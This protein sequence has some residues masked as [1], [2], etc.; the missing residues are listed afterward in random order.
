MARTANNLRSWLGLAENILMNHHLASQT[1]S[2]W[3]SDVRRIT[4]RLALNALCW[5]LVGG[6][7]RNGLV[8]D[9]S[10]E[11]AK[12]QRPFLGGATPREVQL[13]FEVPGIDEVMWAR[14]D[15]CYDQVVAAP[16]GSVAGG[17]LGLMRRTG[18]RII[19]AAQR[20]L[21]LIRDYVHELRRAQWVVEQEAQQLLQ[22][23]YYMRG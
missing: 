16:V 23:S 18:F 22:A 4:P 20:D 9:L 11:G 5:E 8:V 15:A 3:D 12:L 2:A 21:R 7:E 10:A 19:A 1:L 14:A 17:P 6:R 13:E